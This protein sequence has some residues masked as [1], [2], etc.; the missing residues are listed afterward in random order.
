MKIWITRAE[1]G[2]SR[3]AERLRELGHD[4]LNAPV[5]EVHPLPAAIDLGGVGALAFTS[6]NGVRA[7][8]DLCRD[9]GLPVFAVG[10]TTAQAARAAGFDMVVSAEGDV[11]ALGRAIVAAEG[12]LAGAVL[13]PGARDPAGDLVGALTKAGMA[14]RAIAV[15]ETRVLPV[16]V[17]PGAEGVLVHSPKAAAAI[18]GAAVGA[19]AAYCISSAAAAPLA[20]AVKRLTVAAEPDETHLLALLAP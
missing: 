20:G 14:A 5:L 19:L 18:A 3:T 13:H 1:P 4:A 16:T 15:Y 9:R 7:F 11:D 8:A 10:D 12:R 6:A 2:A 17:P